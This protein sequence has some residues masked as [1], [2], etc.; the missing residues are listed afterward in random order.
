MKVGSTFS[1]DAEPGT[2]DEHLKGYLNRATGG[3]VAVVLERAG[4]V[5]IDR[6]TPTRVR[7]RHGW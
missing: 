5:E 7:L 3:W 6:A 1:V 2:L 4:V